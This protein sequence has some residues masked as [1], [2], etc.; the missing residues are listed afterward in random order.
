MYWAALHPVIFAMGVGTVTV[1]GA[2]VLQRQTAGACYGVPLAEIESL[3]VSSGP[4]AG[5]HL[6]AVWHDVDDGSLKVGV[7]V[8]M[9][10]T[11]SS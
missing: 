6:A 2:P 8:A 1:N 11:A 7:E 3:V 5:Y 9:G 10:D 4:Y